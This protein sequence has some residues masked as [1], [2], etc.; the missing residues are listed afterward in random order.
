MQIPMGKKPR[1]EFLAS[2][3]Y[4]PAEPLADMVLLS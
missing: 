3:D 4:T 1:P 2:C